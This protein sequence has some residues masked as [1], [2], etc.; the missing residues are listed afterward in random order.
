MREKEKKEREGEVHSPAVQYTYLHPYSR[1]RPKMFILSLSKRA[2]ST[3]VSDIAV[4]M[5]RKRKVKA[6]EIL[7]ETGK[8]TVRGHIRTKWEGEWAVARK[9]PR[10]W[11]RMMMLLFYFYSTTNSSSKR[12]FHTSAQSHHW[13][14]HDTAPDTRAYNIS[15]LVIACEGTTEFSQSSSL[16]NNSCF[17]IS[18][19]S[20]ITATDDG[21][22]DV[23]ALWARFVIW[24]YFSLKKLTY[25]YYSSHYCTI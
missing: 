1:V 23:L 15:L 9:G 20:I 14:L 12:Y 21:V 25:Y 16:F 10:W 22:Q 13:P 17:F 18:C 2:V 19:F 7:R 3:L 6:N 4:S 8:R 24:L 5:R 11:D